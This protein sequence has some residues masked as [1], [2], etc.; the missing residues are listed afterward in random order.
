MS[1]HGIL[2]MELRIEQAKNSGDVYG[3]DYEGSNIDR[4]P[5]GGTRDRA[6]GKIAMFEVLN[7]KGGNVMELYK[8]TKTFIFLNK[9]CNS[10]KMK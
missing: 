8:V 10:Y 1:K 6:D 7:F 9:E 2:M 3:A 5:M 4:K